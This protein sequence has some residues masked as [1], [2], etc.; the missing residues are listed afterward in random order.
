MKI[1]PGKSYHCVLCNKC[2]TPI[3]LFDADLEKPV[4]FAGPGKLQV[5]CPKCGKVGHYTTEKVRLLQAHT[6]H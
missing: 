6:L 5:E 1:E 2:K 3:P 4:G